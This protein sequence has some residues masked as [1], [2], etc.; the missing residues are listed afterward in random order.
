[1]L[2]LRECDECVSAVAI[3][4]TKVVNDMKLFL[5][6]RCPPRA[7]EVCRQQNNLDHAGAVV[8]LGAYRFFVL[9]IMTLYVGFFCGC[10]CLCMQIIMMKPAGGPAARAPGPMDRGDI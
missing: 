1:M 3:Y 6:K 8:C 4:G 10:L 2:K 9:K 5:F 7:A